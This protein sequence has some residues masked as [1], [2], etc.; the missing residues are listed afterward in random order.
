MHP[1]LKANLVLITVLRA[2]LDA[3]RALI[4]LDGVTAS[5]R[6]EFAR[7][8]VARRLKSAL[9]IAE[10]Y[11]RRMLLVMALEM[12]PMLVDARQPLPARRGKRRARTG[13]ALRFRVFDPR[14]KPVTAAVERRWD[15]AADQRRT[16]RR[17][18]GRRAGCRTP[19]VAMAPLYR[20]LDWLAEV[21]ADPMRKVTRVAVALARFKPGWLCKPDPDIRMPGRWGTEASMLFDVMGHQIVERSRT[22]PPPQ[23][24]RQRRWPRVYLIDWP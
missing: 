23:A 14:F 11:L 8:S 22:R 15:E 20:R 24:P 6:P 4:A 1:V 10:A 21:A 16:T 5:G 9:R 3:V 7:Q 17:L 2:L 19:L 13:T 12:E 18:R